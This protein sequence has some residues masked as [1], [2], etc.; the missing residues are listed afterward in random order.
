MSLDPKITSFCFF[1]PAFTL[2]SQ[3]V[4]CSLYTL[5]TVS[6]NF[7]YKSLETYEK[8]NSVTDHVQ[9]IVRAQLMG[10]SLTPDVYA[11]FCD[12]FIFPLIFS[13]R[14]LRVMHLFG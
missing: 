3:P 11:D 9:L 14:V 12:A 4:I 2:L 8:V 6:C 7:L 13:H 5:K 10:W 1:I